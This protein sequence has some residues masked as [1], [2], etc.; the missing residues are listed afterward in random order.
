MH[1]TYMYLKSTS[2]I[3]FCK[4]L[5]VDKLSIRLFSYIFFVL[6]IIFVYQTRI[7]IY[8]NTQ[9]IM[10]F[11]HIHITSIHEV[12]EENMPVACHACPCHRCVEHN[13]ISLCKSDT[14]DSSLWN[15]TPAVKP[16]CP[17][18][19]QGEGTSLKFTFLLKHMSIIINY[20][21]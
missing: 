19:Q 15:I 21:S 10:R 8:N 20:C 1:N 2:K 14:K 13:E 17:M 9:C 16:C 6:Y 4:N 3:C 12:E 18:T 5:N 7:V 11:V